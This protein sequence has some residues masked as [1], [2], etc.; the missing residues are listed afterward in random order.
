[1][2]GH[3]R[4]CIGIAFIAA[5]LTGS[6]ASAKAESIS[7]Y[8]QAE[9]ST[10]KT[11][12]F[13]GEE[14]EIYLTIQSHSVALDQNF[15]LNPVASPLI[16]RTSN[17]FSEYPVERRLNNNR[18]EE[19]RKFSWRSAAVSTGTVDLTSTLDLSIVIRR[20]DLFFSRPERQYF[21]IPVTGPVITVVPLPDKDRPAGFSGAVG[22]YELK[23]NVSPLE[24]APG[25][26]IRIQ[27]EVLGTGLLENASAPVFSGRDNF[28]IYSP[29]LI[30]SSPSLI[31]EQ[32]VVPLTP[33]ALTIPAVTFSFFDP[34]RKEYRTLASPP[35]ALKLRRDSAGPENRFRPDGEVKPGSSPEIPGEPLSMRTAILLAGIIILLLTAVLR[36][37][38]GG[39]SAGSILAAAMLIIAAAADAIYILR[40]QSGYFQRNV[41]AVSTQ[42]RGRIAPSAKAPQTMGIPAGGYVEKLHEES[43]W[44]LVRF[45]DRQCWIPGTAISR[46][47]SD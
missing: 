4:N 22:Q 38:K 14:F 44:V 36:T 23:V 45:A 42:T 7:D 11:T 10:E 25:D 24:A 16:R 47:I 31:Y 34:E 12:L 33:A 20:T 5:L 30:S 43:G 26:V 28:K 39:L 9:F 21:N 8:V 37:M 27:T 35:V 18:I 32:Q 6:S 46:S 13:A 15:N 40:V 41:Y 29:K 2:T 19:I 1:M 17:G 3:F